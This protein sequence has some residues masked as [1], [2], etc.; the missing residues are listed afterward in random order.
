[1]KRPLASTQAEGNTI[2][3]K[4]NYSAVGTLIGRS[5][6]ISLLAKMKCPGAEAAIKN[7]TRMLE[8]IETQNRHNIA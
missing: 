3:G 1:M 7:F 6:H 8:R 5:T 4:C 2:K